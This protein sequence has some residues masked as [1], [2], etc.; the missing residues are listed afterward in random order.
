MLLNKGGTTILSSRGERILFSVIRELRAALRGRERKFKLDNIQS[1]RARAMIQEAIAKVTTGQS[2][3]RQE[4]AAVMTEIMEG[5]ATPAQFGALVTALHLKGETVDEITGFAEVMR[6]KAQPL[7]INVD[8]VD[9]CGTGGDHSGTFNISTAAAFVVAGAGQ[10]VAKHGNRAAS[11]KCG[12]ADV[13]AELGVKVDLSSEQ[14]TACIEHAGIAFIFAPAFHPSM[15]FAAGPRREIAIRTVFN[16]LG[17]LTN[18]ARPRY[19]VLGI[20]DQRLLETMARA[21]AQLGV[22][23]ALVI[24]GEDGL[25]EISLSAP[26]DVCEVRNGWT[27]RY[28]LTPEDVGLARAPLE[29]IR[30]GDA[31]ENAA[32][33]HEVLAGGSGPHRDIVLLN[34][35]AALY[36]A[37]RVPDIATGVQLAAESIDSGRAQTA[38]ERLIE[39]TQSFTEPVAVPV[40]A[41]MYPPRFLWDLD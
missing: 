2:L 38:L 5:A 35:A 10:P 11:S 4:A 7:V 26:T 31:A 30:G 29:A 40:G 23:H 20:A 15:K 39:V 9:T 25:D 16:I 27:T 37:D 17:P 1:L 24:H 8:V 6:A 41:E 32:I 18:P 33:I 3:S 36:A 22:S 34:A 21:L 14:V 19:Q 28:H 13:L 12:S